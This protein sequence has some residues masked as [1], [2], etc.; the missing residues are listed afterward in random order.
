MIGCMDATKLDIRLL[1]SI[2]RLSTFNFLSVSVS[3]R[4]DTE[5]ACASIAD[6]AVPRCHRW[7]IDWPT[8]PPHCERDGDNHVV[9]LSLLRFI[10]HPSSPAYVAAEVG[11]FLLKGFALSQM[12]GKCQRESV[13]INASIEE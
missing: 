13:V 9:M 10:L 3:N 7:L 6:Q 5:T 11:N 8:Q 1:I 4:L 2:S 12:L